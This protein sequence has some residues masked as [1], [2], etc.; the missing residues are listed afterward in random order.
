MFFKWKQCFFN[1]LHIWLAIWK[2]MLLISKTMI[3]T[4]AS[5]LEEIGVSKRFLHTINIYINAKLLWLFRN[6]G[7]NLRMVKMQGII[8]WNR[9]K[10][11]PRSRWVD[12]IRSATELPLLNS[13]ALAEDRH[14]WRRISEVKTCQPW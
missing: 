13:Y 14:L 8:E 5:M 1:L 3:W 11:R 9:R 12:Q 4:N 6:G 10:G 2:R 7:N